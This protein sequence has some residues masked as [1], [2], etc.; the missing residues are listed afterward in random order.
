[1]LLFA[2]ISVL[3]TFSGPF[4]TSCVHEVFPRLRLLWIK[5]AMTTKWCR[6][7][8]VSLCLWRERSDPV[9]YFGSERWC[10]VKRWRMSH[11]EV[12]ARLTEQTN[13]RVGRGWVQLGTDFRLPPPFWQS[14]SL[15]SARQSCPPHLSRSQ[16]PKI[17]GDA[18]KYPVILS[19]A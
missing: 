15:T 14:P 5:I 4:L 11:P 13:C 3:Q 18:P 2:T 10:Q 6:V 7:G 12:Q 19:V 1:M 17:V 8:Y 9:L 16:S